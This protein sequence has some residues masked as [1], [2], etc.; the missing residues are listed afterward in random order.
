MFTSVPACISLPSSRSVET[1]FDPALWRESPE[2]STS[3]YDDQL[4]LF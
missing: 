1:L 2:F 3:M 4:A